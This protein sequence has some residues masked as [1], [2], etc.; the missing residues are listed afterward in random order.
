MGKSAKLLVEELLSCAGIKI[1]GENPYDIKVKNENLYDRVLRYGALGLGEAYMDGWWEADS[2]DEFINRLLRAHLDEKVKGSMKIK[3]HYLRSRIFN[4]QKGKRSYHVGKHH[5]DLGNDFFKAMLDKNMNYSCGYWKK[6]RN[7]DE[8][9]EDKLELICRK[10]EIK[11]GMRVLDIGCGWGGFAKYAAE[12]CG[13]EVVGITVSKEQVQLARE[14]TKGLSV[15]IRYQDFRDIKGEKFDRVLSIGSFEHVGYKNYRKYMELVDEVLKDDGIS[16]IHTIGSNVSVTTANAWTNKY[17]FP[18][19]H[20]PSIAQISKAME[21]LFVIED[22]HNFGPDY[23]KTLMAWFENFNKSWHKF[24]DKYGERFYRMWKY[25]LLS[26]AGGF[27]SRSAQ[28]WQIVFT[29]PG[30]EQ[31]K[32]VC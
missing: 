21:G 4:L 26:S 22:I 9:Q 14:L 12:K 29:K 8:A 13:A 25:Y 11:E 19:G 1:N 32:R 15:E 17:I 2:V 28:L 20:L 18:N 6:A 16:L 23:D 30:R 5:Y 24:K 10:L 31:P 7:L 27:R 3:W